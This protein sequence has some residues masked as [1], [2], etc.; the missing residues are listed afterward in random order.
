MKR[1]K[2]WSKEE[3]QVLLNCVRENPINLS[4]AFREATIELDRPLTSC[5]NRWY[6]KLNKTEV[7]FVTIGT[8]T[9][10]KNRKIVAV[11]T[12]DNT[13]N[14]KVT[15]WDRIKKLLKLC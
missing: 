1:N 12:S 5:K 6:Q 7:C 2:R 13:E 14:I 9:K 4:K 8:R 3:E 11:N 10:N 15:V